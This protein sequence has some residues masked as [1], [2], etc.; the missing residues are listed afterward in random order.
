[1]VNV[2][3]QAA[4]QAAEP[5]LA[6][7]SSLD[8]PT[9]AARVLGAVILTTAIATLPRIDQRVAIGLL[10][11]V[12]AATLAGRPNLKRLSLRLSIALVVIGMLILPFLLSGQGERAV[13]LSLRALGA[14]TVALAFT[15]DLLGAELARALGALRA[16]TALVEVLEGLALQLDSLK[17]TCVR[18]LL[19]RRLRGAR[20][21]LGAASILP[22][23][24]VRSAERAER[25]DLARRLRGYHYVRPKRSFARHDSWALSIAFASAA[26]LHALA[27]L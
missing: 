9:P 17:T 5:Y 19:A 26:L 3:P 6:L 22:E 8:G 21:P 24:L 23:L 11:C 13:H 27:R 14:A 7:R 25:V 1:V 15:S 18:L 16:P 10:A 12:V 4:E 20:G 2:K